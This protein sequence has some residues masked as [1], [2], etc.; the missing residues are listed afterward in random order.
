MTVSL[1]CGAAGLVLHWHSQTGLKCTP[2][3][4][5]QVA[6]VFPEHWVSLTRLPEK[7]ESKMPLVFVHGVNVR[8]GPKYDKEMQ[9]RN[10][11]FV[12]IFFKL[13]GRQFSADKVISPYWGDLATNIASGTPY[14]PSGKHD[15]NISKAHLNSRPIGAAQEK[16]TDH[17]ED[18]LND[19]DLD[20][21]SLVDLAR[22]ESIAKVVD[23]VIATASERTLDDSLE[24]DASLSEIGFSALDLS[25]RFKSV[26]EQVE[27]LEGVV[28]DAQL[29]L[30]LENEL[31]NDS[32]VDAK[33]RLLSLEH[34]K[35][36][37][38]WLQ[39]RYGKASGLTKDR[40][41]IRTKQVQARIKQL[42]ITAKDSVRQVRDVR[43]RTTTH[44]AAAA[45]TNPMRKLF[46]QR[47]F[48]F[49]G[50][51]FLYFG[52][53]GTPES[54][55]PIVKI[56]SDALDS[57]W[58][59]RTPEDPDLIVVAHSMGANIM[60]DIAS[61]FRS[62]RE[63]DLLI[64]VA[65]QFP[66]FADLHMFPGLDTHHRPIKKPANVKRWI[67][68]YDMND[69]FG[70]AAQPMFEDIEELDFA[71]GRLGIA[72]HADCFK[73]VS[74]YEQMAKAVQQ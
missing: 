45:I 12:N 47:L 56:I 59:Q 25:R 17:E 41:Q 43:R 20:G 52:Q 50:D 32:T 4:I 37:G 49:I 69:I 67:N 24:D 64:T 44:V 38:D 21:T 6:F 40:L 19:H 65:A 22:T 66:L 1:S 46:H 30:K 11:Y 9:L 33:R 34:M 39:A 27:W 2:L 54:P 26:D 15:K 68:V 8:L 71:S 18:Q 70:F 3:P 53:R 48:Q 10:Q 5:F 57:G 42:S 62:D 16:T 29:I 28:N 74:L 72:T 60:C 31:K 61:H 63:I 14:L 51:S 7:D 55:G 58:S 23:L 73:F 36:A 13:L 35:L